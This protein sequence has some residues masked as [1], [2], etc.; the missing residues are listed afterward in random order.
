MK[1]YIVLFLIGLFLIPL[2]GQAQLLEVNQTVFG[3]D[4]A[5]CAYGLEKRI[6]Q[7]AGVQ[8]AS[9][10]LNEGLLTA[11]LSKENQLTLQRIRK[12]VEE[13]GFKAKEANITVTGTVTKNESGSLVLETGAGERFILEAENE[14]K[15]EDIS[16]TKGSLT[17]T[18]KAET[19]DGAGTKLWVASINNPKA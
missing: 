14:R 3:M 5:P 18:G 10:S 19:S 8:S 11:T 17:I 7:I 9:V 13:S 16:N 12:A 1:N 6:N 4:C 2:Q 15:L